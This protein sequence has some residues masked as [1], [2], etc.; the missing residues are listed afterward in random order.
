MIRSRIYARQA[1]ARK[2]P[3]SVYLPFLEANHLWGATGAKHGYG[4]FLKPKKT[5]QHQNH[6]DEILVAVATFSAKRK[7][8]RASHNFHSFELLRFCTLLDTTVV[9]GLTKLVAAFVKEVKAKLAESDTDESD[10]CIDIITSIDRD[11]GSNTWPDFVRMDVMDPVP[12]FVGGL[13]GLRRHAVGAGLTPLEQNS[14]NSSMAV[15]AMLRAG[16]P[17]NLLEELQQHENQISDLPWKVAAQEGFQPVF[18][19]GVERLMLVVDKGRN[20]PLSPSELWE[21]S[22]PRYVREHYS[23]NQG[24]EN[25]IKCIRSARVQ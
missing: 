6:D 25:M 3:K 13:D 8:K 2:I 10:T 5:I 20:I 15:S 16:L 23:S 24:V 1:V 11:F 17:Q 18:D 22:M 4:L 9:G 12:M 14:E 21:S 7:V 19:A